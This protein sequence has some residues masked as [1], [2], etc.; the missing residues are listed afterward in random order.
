VTA[1]GTDPREVETALV[2]VLALERVGWA[3]RLRSYLVGGLFY[4]S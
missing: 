2:L 4:P 1:R 3:A